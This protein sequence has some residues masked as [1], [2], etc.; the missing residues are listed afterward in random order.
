MNTRVYFVPSG[1]RTHDLGNVYLYLTHALDRS[2]TTA[3]LEGPVISIQ[4]IFFFQF[5]ILLKLF[6][7]NNLIELISSTLLKVS[8]RII[9]NFVGTIFQGNYYSQ[10]YSAI[11][12]YCPCLVWDVQSLAIKQ[13]EL[14]YLRKSESVSIHCKN[15]F[16]KIGL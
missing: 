9:Q 2:A 4:L 7:E 8:C 11:K 16:L 5:S 12:K 1:I 14:V 10:K 3:G 6:Y 15:T 13:L